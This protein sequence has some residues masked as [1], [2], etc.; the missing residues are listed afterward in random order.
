MGSAPDPRYMPLVV[1]LTARARSVGGIQCASTV[2]T[3]GM[4]KPCRGGR[5]TGCAALSASGTG[6]NCA[7]CRCGAR[8][9]RWP[10]SAASPAGVHPRWRTSLW[11]AAHRDYAAWRAATKQQAPHSRHAQAASKACLYRLSQ[12]PLAPSKGAPGR[13]PRTPERRPRHVGWLRSWASPGWPGTTARRMRSACARRP[14][15]APPS[16]RGSDRRSGPEVGVSWVGK[17]VT[18]PSRL[19]EHRTRRGSTKRG[20]LEKQRGLAVRWHAP[21]CYRC[22]RGA[23]APAAAAGRHLRHCIAPEEC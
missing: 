13:G 3:A 7:A 15:A 16:R 18:A 11:H 19:I 17:G 4:R 6:A 9:P 1:R 22:S 21:P 23:A 14:S 5:K 10:G 20:E 12:H 2:C 8:P